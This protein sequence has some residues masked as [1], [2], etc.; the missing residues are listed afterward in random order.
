[1]DA[2]APSGPENQKREVRRP[3]VFVSYSRRDTI[4]ANE[5][6][7]HL[8]ARAFQPFLDR[9]DIAPGEPWKDRLA[10]LIRVADTMVYLVSPDS[11]RSTICEWEVSEADRLG[12]RIIPVVCRQTDADTI[13]PALG[14][15]NFLFATEPADLPNAL[16]RLEEALRQD[17]AWIREHTRLT[18]IAVRWD[19]GGRKRSQALRGG[20]L[21]AAVRWLSH[22]PGQSG[23]PTTL[24]RDLVKFSGRAQRLRQRAWVAGSTAI[25]IL[26]LALAGF[27]EINRRR[28]DDALQ[29]AR[30]TANTLVTDLADGLRDKVGMPVTLVR[31]I[32][33]PALA[34]QEH[35][36]SSG[37]ASPA[38]RSD[39][40]HAL[41][42]MTETLVRIG[43][44]QGA[45][46]TATRSRDIAEE[47]QRADPDNP[48]Q[49]SQLSESLRA[50]AF[51]EEQ[52]GDRPGA[53]AA[54][55]RR[56]AVARENLPTLPSEQT[57]H[58]LLDAL[59]MSGGLASTMDDADSAIKA[60][61]EAL[62]LARAAAASGAAPQHQ[63]D[64]MAILVQLAVIKLEAG[65]V[66]GSS[67][68]LHEALAL[69]TETTHDE[70]DAAARRDL[71][72]TLM[73]MA[74]SFYRLNDPTSEFASLD[75]SLGIRR[76]LAADKDNYVAQQ[77]LAD[78]LFAAGGLRSVNGLSDAG[79]QYF[80]ESI[81]IYRALA[82]DGSHPAVRVALATTLTMFAQAKLMA[83]IRPDEATAELVEA[84][85]L[86]R[87]VPTGLDQQ[88]E[89]LFKTAEE[90]LA[91][92][93][94]APSH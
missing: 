71:A 29:A 70:T 26:A 30:G 36:I 39:Q 4:F 91:K 12:K 61:E 44:T 75:Q 38:L 50:L 3:R 8:E 48:A 55:I 35:L 54:L 53:R 27:A 65:D 6:V 81:E 1:L 72:M 78:A 86:Y 21:E 60:L 77:A 63:H 42:R 15:L 10:G 52:V 68:G 87:A 41:A 66:A 37:G 58:D 17:L 11:I 47:L 74:V 24:H 56:V 76:D 32:L 22:P 31:S 16:A 7:A 13:P 2:Q 64:L 43:D 51:A 49:R 90:L 73:G 46:K 94:A 57:S 88:S 62:Q 82:R 67:Q 59:L 69:A 83:Q 20:D 34:L 19:A 5:L 93:K 14:R 25:A 33:E 45:L 92:L 40:S 89:A 9:T 28:A 79:I 84:I 18:E 85:D 80:N 23:Q